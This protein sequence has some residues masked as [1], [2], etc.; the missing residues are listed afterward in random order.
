MITDCDI[1]CLY[2]DDFDEVNCLHFFLA[3]AII[4]DA[5]ATRIVCGLQRRS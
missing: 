5:A 2:D 3:L 1:S 4:D